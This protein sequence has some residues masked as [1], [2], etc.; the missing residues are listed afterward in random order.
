[1]LLGQELKFK[2]KLCNLKWG[3][4]FSAFP[5]L[6]ASA[7]SGREGNG[8]QGREGNGRQGREGNGSFC[9]YFSDIIWRFQRKSVFLWEILN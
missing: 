5:G 9:V 3:T 8:R 1:M 2:N 4:F 7:P 6:G